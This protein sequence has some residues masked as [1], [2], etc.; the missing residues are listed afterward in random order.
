M[1][2]HVQ[3]VMTSAT[4][5]I[6]SIIDNKVLEINYLCKTKRVIYSIA[7]IIGNIVKW[8]KYDCVIDNKLEMHDIPRG[9]YMLFIIEGDSL[10]KVRFMKN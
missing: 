2:K 7:D 9:T 4:A 1:F 5:E 3:L 6:V 10:T 8:G